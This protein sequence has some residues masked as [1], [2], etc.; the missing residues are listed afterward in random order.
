MAREY[1]RA[2]TIH[3]HTVAGCLDCGWSSDAVNA[4]AIGAIHHDR[5]QHR[6]SVNVQT[7]IMYGDGSTHDPRQLTLLEGCDEV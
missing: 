2:T 7:R 1:K 3:T 4:Q 5:T 6:V